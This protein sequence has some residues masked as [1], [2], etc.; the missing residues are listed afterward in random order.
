MLTG[1]GIGIA[2]ILAGGA[3]AI[4]FGKQIIAWVQRY[5]FLL[6]GKNDF[7]PTL[8]FA[9]FNYCSK[10][11][12]LIQTRSRVFTGRRAII[13]SDGSE[14]LVAFDR[15]GHQP[16]I[17]RKGWRFVRI[18][19]GE[20]V[21][22]HS[23]M[24]HERFIAV[25][26]PRFMWNQDKF[27]KNAMKQYALD[28]GRDAGE[29]GVSRFSVRRFYGKSKNTLTI[30]AASGN[31]KPSIAPNNQEFIEAQF[32]QALTIN[33]PLNDIE[34]DAGRVPNPFDVFPLPTNI[35]EVV[36][37]TTTWFD[38][39]NWYQSKNIPWRRGLLV[40]GQPGTG[41]TLFLR[42]IAQTLDIPVFVFDLSSLTNEEFNNG[43]E[44]ALRESPS[45]VLLEDFD[46]VFH[47]RKNVLGESGGG[48]TFDC[49]LN[50]ISGIQGANGI[51][52]CITTNHLNAIDPAMGIPD[53]SGNS[54]RPGRI[55][56]VVEIGPMDEQCRRVYAER[57]LGKDWAGLDEI[58]AG[59]AGLTAAQFSELIQRKCL[60]QFWCKN[61]EMGP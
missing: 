58:V 37:E 40:Y 24:T 49:V 35:L 13:K 18:S 54:S 1:S 61:N 55:D 16:I 53:P 34:F 12:A 8:S 23:K 41:K 56:R 44:E 5:I 52:L 57:L 4:A 15:L 21:W 7:D 3:T 9:I 19:P 17:F 20:W 39:Q 29:T 26:L 32:G 43:W 60:S 11:M 47:G 50:C 6:V 30:A 51:L 45:M 59:S 25:W 48:L 10:N 22:N 31:A 28:R 46:A 36:K 14:Q 27:I 33:H 2:A 38:S 42:S